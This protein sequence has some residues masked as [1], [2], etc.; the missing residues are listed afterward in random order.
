[1]FCSL[2]KSHPRGCS[3]LQGEEVL[4]S[5]LGF[6]EGLVLVWALSV[7]LELG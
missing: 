6:A 2:P 7:E 5:P 3:S 4:E 1:M